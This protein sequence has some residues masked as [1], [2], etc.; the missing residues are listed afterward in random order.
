MSSSIR[1]FEP[2]ELPQRGPRLKPLYRAIFDDST[3]WIGKKISSYGYAIKELIAQ[4]FFRFVI[5]RQPKTRVHIQSGECY[6]LSEEIQNFDYLP[7]DSSSFY[8][9]GVYTG[10]GEILLTAMFLCEKDL[11]DGNIGINRKKEV[12]KIDGEW[13]FEESALLTATDVTALPFLDTFTPSRWLDFPS[14]ELPTTHKSRIVDDQ[15]SQAGHFRNEINRTILLICLLSDQVILR[16]VQAYLDDALLDNIY[17]SF[18]NQRRSQLKAAALQEPSFRA[19]IRDKNTLRVANEL[20]LNIWGFKTSTAEVVFTIFDSDYTA[21]LKDARLALKY[22]MLPAKLDQLLSAIKAAAINSTD[23]NVYGFVEEQEKSI[24]SLV[25]DHELTEAMVVRLNDI[26]SAV[27]SEEVM[28]VR[29]V[30]GK[31]RKRHSSESEVKAAKIE[32]A[33]IETPLEARETVLSSPAVNSVQLA[34]ASH[35]SFW[36]RGVVYKDSTGKIDYIKAADSYKN[37][38]EPPAGLLSYK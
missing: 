11:N 5:T 4:E 30:I 24:G 23:A 13:C 29:G 18:I 31:L 19:Y 10:L 3:V 12:I 2:I 35:T 32:S 8:G 26:F 22:M 7:R 1:S 20:L 14:S 38:I 16:F 17:V 28:R 25:Y 27:S 15:L 9:N 34:L 21:L 37:L 6:I 36:K 33:L